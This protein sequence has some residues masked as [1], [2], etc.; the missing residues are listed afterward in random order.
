MSA[1]IVYL[2]QDPRAGKI[3]SLRLVNE[4]LGGSADQSWAA[5]PEDG[6]EIATQV[7]TAAAHWLSERL[8]T[9]DQSASDVS[10]LCIDVEGSLCSWLS[11]PSADAKTVETL[12]RQAPSSDGDLGPAPLTPLAHFA[13]SPLDAS[14]QPLGPEA[15]DTAL[16]KS[17]KK[18]AILPSKRIPVLVAADAPARL[19]IDALDA[20]GIRVHRVT[21]LWQALAAA[22]DAP[23]AGEP[24]L[25]TATTVATVLVDPVGRIVWSWSIRGTL[26]A[27]GTLRVPLSRSDDGVDLPILTSDHAAR[28]CTEWLSWSAQVGCGPTRIVIIAPEGSPS[29]ADFGQTLTKLWKGAT[30]DFVTTPDPVLA[31][32]KRV[33]AS[34]E[35]G[36][37]VARPTGDALTALENRPGSMH[38]S[39]HVWVA[40]G[41]AALAVALFV[42]AFRLS[43]DASQSDSA[44]N[45]YREQWTKLVET[46]VPGAMTSLDGP[47]MALQD[48][49]DKKEKDFKPPERVELALPI[50]QEL[51]TLSMVLGS[52]EIQLD[53][54]D[55]DSGQ[56]VVRLR[57]TAASTERAEEIREALRAI[58]GSNIANWSE[59]QYPP[60]AQ[61]GQKLTV[62]YLGSW[63]ENLR[64]RAPGSGG[65]R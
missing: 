51:E 27:G 43:R 20:R 44:A 25:T 58:G 9:N 12:A 4:R 61:P 2:A 36:S 10:L 48:E 41:V 57:V 59:P 50:L 47:L 52:G 1:R 22:W 30:A 49:V 64:K 39:S 15:V 11:A 5:R 17:N 19:L 24:G 54:L 42:L 21:S 6:G 18:A 23:P 56:N 60:N 65:N 53:E 45:S 34:V 31:T 7:A 8:T 46:A 3:R 13:Q 40:A 26:L 16:A 14:V 62:T 37:G 63:K 29:T 38:R 55:L 35:V 32:L 33:A 28:L